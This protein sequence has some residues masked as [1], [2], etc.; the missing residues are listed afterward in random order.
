[1]TLNRSNYVSCIS[2][3]INDDACNTGNALALVDVDLIY[4]TL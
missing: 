2:R 4:A 3:I 1:M